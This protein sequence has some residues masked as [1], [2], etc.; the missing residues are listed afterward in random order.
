MNLNLV[1]DQIGDRL[2]AIPGYK[3]FRYPPES[4]TPP[5]LIISYP[6]Q[7]NYDLTNGRGTDEILGLSITGVVGAVTSLAARRKVMDL[8][9]G[10]S[11]GLKSLIESQSFSSCDDIQIESAQFDVVKITEV[12]Y[13]SVTF[14]ATIVGRGA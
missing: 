4:V 14:S 2:D 9:G 8:A 10:G 13:I 7:V 6:D 11:G 12:D 3:I 1:V 5:C